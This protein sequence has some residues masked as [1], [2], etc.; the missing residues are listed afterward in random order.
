MSHQHVQQGVSISLGEAG[1]FL[2]YIWGRIQAPSQLKN[3]LNFPK[4]LNKFPNFL[5]KCKTTIEKFGFSKPFVPSATNINRV[6]NDQNEASN[7]KF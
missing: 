4:I 2:G 5:Q 7:F 6:D 1:I 3:A